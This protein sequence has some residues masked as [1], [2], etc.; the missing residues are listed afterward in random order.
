MWCNVTGLLMEKK[1][2]N[3]KLDFSTEVSNYMFSYYL[4]YKQDE[5]LLRGVW[6]GD[7]RP[8]VSCRQGFEL[9]QPHYCTDEALPNSNKSSSIIQIKYTQGHLI[10][11]IFLVVFLLKSCRTVWEWKMGLIITVVEEE[12][13]RSFTEI[14]L[15]IPHSKNSQK[16][17]K[18]LYNLINWFVN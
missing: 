2:T 5:P 1:L 11:V 10:A 18:M 7:I 14:Q 8:T 6:S 13:F 3:Q 12:V 4:T 16:C 17:T 15:Q 9:S